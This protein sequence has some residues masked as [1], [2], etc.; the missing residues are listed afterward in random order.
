VNEPRHPL[1]LEALVALFYDDPRELGRFV[2]VPA[3]EVPPGYHE[4]LAHEHHMTVTVEQFHNCRVD[5]RVLRK[6]VT[7]SHYSRLILLSRQ[8]DGQV[9][10]FGIMRV[11][12]AY[13]GGEVRREIEAERAPLGRILIEHDVLRQVHLYSLYQVAPGPDLCRHFGLE[14]PRST[15]GRTAVIDCNHEP[16]IELL[17]I[18]TP[19][20]GVLQ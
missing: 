16:A 8:S 4:L 15:Y 17:E 18:V 5:V 14:T 20:G 13:L 7:A 12:F 10:Q 3:A 2:E 1:E 11:N 6:H 19:L 9:V